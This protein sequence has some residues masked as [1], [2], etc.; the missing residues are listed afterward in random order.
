M[1][2]PH[3]EMNPRNLREKYKGWIGKKVI[4]GLTSFHYVCGRWKDIE[5][6]DALF[7]VG[8]RELRVKMNEIETIAD[9]P[10][11]QAEFFK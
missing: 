10:E 7:A 11:A 4:V 3:D 1:F 5:D 2:T 6:Y 9:A 8:D